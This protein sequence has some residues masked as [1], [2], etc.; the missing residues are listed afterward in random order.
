MKHPY[1]PLVIFSFFL[2]IGGCGP[3]LETRPVIPEASRGCA[4]DAKEASI[5]C[6]AAK[7]SD[8]NTCM[9]EKSS[10]RQREV[11]S[12][13]SNKTILMA[14]YESCKA[15]C[16][17]GSHY[18]P[19]IGTQTNNDSAYCDAQDCSKLN[20]E[21]NNLSIPSSTISSDACSYI[22]ESCEADYKLSFERCGGIYET[23][24]VENCEEWN[25]Q[26][27]STGMNPSK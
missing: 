11:E 3:V 24:C 16:L 9:T 13:R 6:R 25:K 17:T 4:A 27:R 1:K 26:N 8:F 15:Q 5:A 12:L 18:S 19:K 21:L 20:N 14:Q 2:V 10:L 22:Y 23:Y 7:L